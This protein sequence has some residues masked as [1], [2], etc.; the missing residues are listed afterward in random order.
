MELEYS[1]N[2]SKC[3]ASVSVTGQFVVE[4]ISH[5]HVLTVTAD[6]GLVRDGSPQLVGCVADI[7]GLVRL[8]ALHSVTECVESE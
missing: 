1:N 3:N 2:L 7:F 6:G 5:Q 4:L 8:Q